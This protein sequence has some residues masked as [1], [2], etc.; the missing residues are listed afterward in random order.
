MLKKIF[1]ITAICG[2]IIQYANAQ[3]AADSLLDFIIKNNNRSS[4]YLQ[5][6]DSVIV[7]INENKLMPL[8]S[9]V[10]IIIAVEFAKQAAYKVFSLNSAISLADLNKYYIKNTDG[11]AHP[12]WINYE[13]SIG[14]IK[15][16]SVR[17]LDVARGI[18]MFNSNAN[19]EYLMDLLGFGNIQSDI[20]MFGLKQ[21]TPVYPLVSSLLLYQNGNIS[22]NRLVKEIQKMEDAEY[23]KAI[24]SIHTAL[25]VDER[26]K[27]NF[28]ARDFTPKLQKLWN[29]RLPASTTKEYVRICRI[30]NNRLILNEETYN[31][32]GKL[33]ETTM[34][35]P[36]NNLWLKHLGAKGSSTATILTKALYATL[37]DGTKIEMAYF[38]NN[39]TINE[40]KKLQ[41]WMHDFELKI[42]K[43]ENF[44]KKIVDGFARKK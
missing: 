30:I 43:D 18:I 23:Y 4:F 38:L 1:F 31:V 20:R 15:S 39:L 14:N 24:Y 19:A 17:L 32:L 36:A 42:L 26:Y 10:N 28:R 34:E 25:Q 22:A 27:L 44:R 33:L 11:D 8:G 3:S 41:S 13:N 37:L 9:T 35:T 29:D 2:C 21:H 40:N 5:K 16:E 6:N 12:N 7:R